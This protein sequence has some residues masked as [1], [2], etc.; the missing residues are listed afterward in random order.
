MTMRALSL[1]GERQ[2][3]EAIPRFPHN[4]VTVPGEIA[5]V[6]RK[7]DA[8]LGSLCNIVNNQALVDGYFQQKING[9][10]ATSGQSI[11]GAV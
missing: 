2:P 8:V 6:A 11:W 9:M 7:A 10:D 1:R 5:A 4:E 3:D